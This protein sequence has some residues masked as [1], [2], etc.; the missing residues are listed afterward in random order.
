MA[1]GSDRGVAAVFGLLGAVLL[2]LDGVI[3]LVSGVVYLAL[4]RNEA[5]L[6]SVDQG[7]ILVV[8]GI[9]IAFF[10]LIGRPRTR[11]RAVASGVVLVVIAFFAWLAL[12]L[13]TGVLALLGLIFVLISGVLF[14]V[15]AR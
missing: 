13:G 7:I 2:V 8:L 5:A 15:S 3:G 1:S 4:R 9:V 11:D 6:G 12:G 14:L 10:A